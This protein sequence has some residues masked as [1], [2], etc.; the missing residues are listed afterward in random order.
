MKRPC[1]LNIHAIRYNLPQLAFICAPASPSSSTSLLSFALLF[2]CKLLPHPIVTFAL[3]FALESIFQIYARFS[4]ST[5]FKSPAFGFCCATIEYR[6]SGWTFFHL[7][8]SILFIKCCAVESIPASFCVLS[9]HLPNVD[10]PVSSSNGKWICTILL[11]PPSLYK[12][13]KKQQPLLLLFL[14]QKNNICFSWG[15]IHSCG[16]PFRR[17]RSGRNDSSKCYCQPCFLKLNGFYAFCLYLLFSMKTYLS[18]VK[19]RHTLD[20]VCLFESMRQDLNQ[21]ERTFPILPRT[22]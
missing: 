18:N 15:L 3:A 11:H 16:M 8:S 6:F 19:K 10:S 13:K 14:Y 9:V 21:T 12:F 17:H 22:L 1:K 20:C 4:L 2:D 7:I 5:F